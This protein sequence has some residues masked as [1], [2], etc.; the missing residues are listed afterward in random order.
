LIE[1]IASPENM[2]LAFNRTACAKRM[3]FG[4][5]EFKEYKSINLIKLGQELLGGSYQ[6][7]SYKQFYVFEPKKRLISALEFKDRLA[8]HALMAVIGDIFDA[9]FLPNTYACRVG[10][11]THGGVRY[12]QSELRKDPKPMYYLKTDYTKFFPSVDH[13]LLLA[14]IE[15]KIAC[16]RTMKI[17]KQLVIPGNVGIPIGSLTSQLFANIYGSQLDHFIHHELK[18]RRWA[19]YMDDVVIL[20]NDPEQL[21]Q[22]FEKIQQFSQEKLKLTISKWQCASVKRGINFLGYRIW[23]THKLIRKDSVLRAKHKIKHFIEHHEFLNLTKFLA[24]WRG[25]ASWADTHNLFNWLDNK[26]DYANY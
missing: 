14:M 3:S 24:S 6:V 5:L 8:Q 15:R 4:Y 23:A 17:I 22:D 18:H 12:L 26:Y 7:G 16:E 20:G 11:G 13:T 2:Q 10:K 25:H 21:R 19:R 9:M 1:R